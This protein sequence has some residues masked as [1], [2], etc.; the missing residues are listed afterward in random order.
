M[1]RGIF[2]LE[3]IKQTFEIQGEPLFE[4]PNVIVNQPMIIG[5]VGKN[6]SGKTTL[7]KY[8]EETNNDVRLVEQIKPKDLER[9][10]GEVTKSYLLGAVS[11]H[12]QILLL[13]EPTTHLDEN[14]RDWLI[15]KIKRLP[16]I[17]IITSHDRYFL[18][19]VVSQIWA[20]DDGVLEI[21]DGDYSHYKEVLDHRKKRHAE[22]YRQYI[23]EKKEIQKKIEF[24]RNQATRSNVAPGSVDHGDDG[25]SPYFNKLQKKLFKSAKAFEARIDRL[26]EV[27]QPDKV[28]EIK[29]YNHD[30]TRLGK[31]V[32]LRYEGDIIIG[33][34]ELIHDVK[35]FIKNQEKV[36][37]TGVNGSGKTTLVKALVSEHN[38]LKVGYFHQQLESLDIEDSILENV[39]EDSL[40]DE[41]TARTMLARLDINRDKVFE[42]VKWISGGE[43][44]KVQLVKVL[45]GQCDVLVLDEPSNFLDLESVE[46]LESMLSNFP[47][48]VLLI[49]HDRAFINNVCNR[50]F[51]I[52]DHQLIDQSAAV[53]TKDSNEDQLLVIENKISQ[54]LSDMSVEPTKA[55]EESF[56]NLVAQKRA[57]S[58]NGK[59]YK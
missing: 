12:P 1:N 8:I 47:N 28:R 58:E 26:E 39:L 55:L 41:T 10:G 57:L 13:D 49:S 54:V 37:I 38:H 46:A 30:A 36:A 16:S 48:T 51:K 31:K 43:R 23:N 25:S 22:E 45:L 24:K 32:L 44:I 3:I 19:A 40:Y 59:K 18:D 15:G 56:E 34:R 33:K 29:F 27:E 14:N 21:Y 7:L 35:L 2:M 50:E 52:V 11:S 6:G 17:V 5:L 42:K 53:H 4:V 9:S 20:I